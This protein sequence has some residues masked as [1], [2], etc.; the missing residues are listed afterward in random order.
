MKVSELINKLNTS[1]PDA[2]VYV[3]FMNGDRDGSALVEDYWLYDE[4]IIIKSGSVVIDIT[5][6]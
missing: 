1:N 4:H 3:R 5:E 2:E 6:D